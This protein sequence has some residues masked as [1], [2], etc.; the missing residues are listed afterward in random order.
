[1]V[2]AIDIGNT[3][4]VMG[5]MQDRKI[6]FTER[7]A[8]NIQKTTMDYMV[9][10]KRILEMHGY[11]VKETDGSIISS[12][13][14]P[15]A[16]TLCEAILRLTGEPP[17]MVDVGMKTGLNIRM[18]QPSKV[19]RDLIVAAVAG[20]TDYSLPLII[21]D[22]GTATTFS[23]VDAGKNY[24]GTVILPGLN[25]GLEALASRTSQ[26]PKIGL[27]APEKV[28]GTNTV[29]SLQSGAIYGNAACIDGML[30]RIEEEM[31]SQAT[32]IAT[33]GLAP[34]VTR[35]CERKILVDQDLLLRGLM[36][37]YE[38]NKK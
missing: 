24:I 26:L 4:I 16:A 25:L 22:M 23:A 29:A 5:C 18:D 20:M 36:Y 3:N 37:L 35:Y 6:L 15:A 34:L 31:G 1:M 11:S 19:G 17:M 10:L 7:I 13:V 9:L 27:A 2:L 30:K 38:K 33:G 12:V 28:L 21:V 32:V 14:P 8:T